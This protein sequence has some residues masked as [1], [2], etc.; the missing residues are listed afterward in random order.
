M[1]TRTRVQSED[2]ELKLARYET[3]VYRVSPGCIIFTDGSLL[4]TASGKTFM[5]AGGPNALLNKRFDRTLWSRQMGQSSP[6]NLSQFEYSTKP[7][8]S[9]LSS[10]IPGQ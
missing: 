4:A 5:Y 3:N 9:R 6:F 10:L 8:G 2:H 7:V 1:A